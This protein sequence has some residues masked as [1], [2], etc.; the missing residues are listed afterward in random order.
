MKASF[1]SYTD[2]FLIFFLI[3][4]WFFLVFTNFYLF[5]VSTGLL[6]LIHY[7]SGDLLRHTG[8]P[9]SQRPSNPDRAR[10]QIRPHLTGFLPV[11]R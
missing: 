8:L 2:V 4:F 6:F 7:L 10:L 9:L 3:F 11:S 1:F 5:L